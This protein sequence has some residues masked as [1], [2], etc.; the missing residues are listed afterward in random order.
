MTP[1]TGDMAR[2]FLA[3][4]LSALVTGFSSALYFSQTTISRSEVREIIREERTNA[5]MKIARTEAKV[6]LIGDRQTDVRIALATLI[7]QLQAIQAEL[8]AHIGKPDRPN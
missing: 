4:A 5:D 3:V 2:L 7:A 8:E 6:D 1:P